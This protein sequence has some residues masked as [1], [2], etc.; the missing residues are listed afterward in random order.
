MKIK[1]KEALFYA[2][3]LLKMDPMNLLSICRT[4]VLFNL[5]IGLY[6]DFFLIF[7][8]G[9]G[10][11]MWHVTRAL[12]GMSRKVCFRLVLATLMISELEVVLW[13]M[14]YVSIDHPKK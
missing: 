5:A 12:I 13:E 14:Y 11:E 8:L 9:G 6:I 10:W 2:T 7:F 1:T 4:H 3:F